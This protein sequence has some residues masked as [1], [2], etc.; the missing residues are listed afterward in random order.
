MSTAADAQAEPRPDTQQHRAAEN[1]V[2]GF[3]AGWRDPAGPQE[4][5]EHFTPLLDPEI[6]LI[7]PAMPELVGL[8]TA[9]EKALGAEPQGLEHAGA[10]YR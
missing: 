9:I 5:V 8:E 4:F 3:A 10:G 6:R 7:Q 2:A 1:W